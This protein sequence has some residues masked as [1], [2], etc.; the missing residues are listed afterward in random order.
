MAQESR[1]GLDQSIAQNIYDNTQ[2]EIRASMVRD[3]LNDFRDSFFNL[4]DDRL[5][6]VKFNEQTTLQQY[7]DQIAGSVPKSGRVLNINIGSPNPQITVDNGIILEASILER[8]DNTYNIEIKFK[9]SIEGKRIIPVLHTRS[10]NFND[11]VDVTA[12]VIRFVSNQRIMVGISQTRS[13][14]QSLDLEIITI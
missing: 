4:I 5:A 9:E 10:L 3:V 11:Q 6:N 12:P 7:L 14:A 13:D 8:T 2:K 1:T